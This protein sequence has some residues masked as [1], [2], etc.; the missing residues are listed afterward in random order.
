MASTT[1][2]PGEFHSTNMI[3]AQFMD[4][5]T[6]VSQEYNLNGVRWAELT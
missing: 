2:N 1:L 3:E 5:G 4:F 6:Y